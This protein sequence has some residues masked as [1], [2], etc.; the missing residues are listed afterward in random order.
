MSYSKHYSTKVHYSGTVSCSYP[1]SEHGG[2][3]RVHYD[4]Y[5][6][7]DID[8]V[9][10]T[11]PFDQSVRDAS[12]ALGL[13]AGALSATEAAQVEQ[14]R[15]SAK[16]ISQTA[17]RG[18]YRTLTSELSAQVSEF[19]SSMKS[20]VGLLVEQGRQVEQVHSQMESDYHAIKARYTRLFAGLD[21]ELDQRVHELDRPAFQLSKQAMQGVVARPYEESAA[22]ILVHTQDTSTTPLKL[23][24]ARAK[25][26]ASHALNTLGR[27]CG[28]ITGYSD[29]VQNVMSP[30]AEKG[31][32]Y[33][34]VVYSFQTDMANMQ[35]RIVVHKP[36]FIDD[37]QVT[38]HVIAQVANSGQAHW[39]RLAPKDQE[40]LDQYFLQRLEKYSVSESGKR[41]P[42]YHERVCNQIM[43]LYKRANTTTMYQD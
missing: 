26:Y 34:P 25:A 12:G 20:T 8:V 29:A 18:F 24:C 42:A 14:I 30:V 32:V 35:Q 7:V 9:V 33:A 39:Q 11:D 13:V 41:N 38:R 5:V 27:M 6:P 22:K 3:K 43:S 16:K 4:G 15:R 17:I 37:D 40:A 36:A 19:G 28:Y 1:A 31:Y 23:M 10:D 2:S 21:R